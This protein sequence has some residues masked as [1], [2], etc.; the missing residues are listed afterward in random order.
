MTEEEAGKYH[1]AINLFLKSSDFEK[2]KDDFF[3]E[4]LLN[5]FEQ[6]L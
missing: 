5:L 6:K 2:Y 4:T 1:E 3:A